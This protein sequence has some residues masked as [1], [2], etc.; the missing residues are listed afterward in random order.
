[1]S[2]VNFNRN[3]DDLHLAVAGF[4]RSKY[5]KAE[6][7]VDM[8]GFKLPPKLANKAKNLRSR[9]AWPD[10]FMPEPRKGYHGLYVELKIEGTQLKRKNGN[11]STSHIAEQAEMLNLLS[12]RGYKAVFAVGIDEAMRIIN[13]YLT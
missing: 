8:S 13:Q 12:M 5:P 11:W 3:E 9:R 4:I 1:M 7:N 2:R 6:F 10:L